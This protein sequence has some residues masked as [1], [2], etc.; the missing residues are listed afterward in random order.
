[1]GIEKERIEKIFD[2]FYQVDSTSRRKAGGSGLGLTISREI[3]RAH[4]SDISV[5]SGPG[6]GSNFHFRLKKSGQ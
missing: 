5:E 1:M 2:K 3:I 6:K 4:G